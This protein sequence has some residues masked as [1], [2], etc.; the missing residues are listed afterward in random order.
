M[1]IDEIMGNFLKKYSKS[2]ISKFDNWGIKKLG[3]TKIDSTEE[4]CTLLVLSSIYNAFH[5]ASFV[6]IDKEL[7]AKNKIENL[8]RIIVLSS[9]VPL[10]REGIVGDWFM[11]CTQVQENVMKDLKQFLLNPNENELYTNAILSM[12]S[13]CKKHKFDYEEWKIEIEKYKNADKKQVLIGL[14]IL[15][16]MGLL[17]FSMIGYIQKSINQSE[18]EMLEEQ[19]NY[20]DSSLENIDLEQVLDRKLS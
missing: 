12:Q 19:K 1:D 10:C 2:F 20:D 8:E 6:V 14:S 17:C 15:I 18:I 5:K 7:D 3:N 4:W 11:E 13:Y 9:K 16:G